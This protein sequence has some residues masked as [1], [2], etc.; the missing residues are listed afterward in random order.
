MQFETKADNAIGV[1]AFRVPVRVHMICLAS[2]LVNVFV[3]A[4]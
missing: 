4:S 2:S 1:P 3:F